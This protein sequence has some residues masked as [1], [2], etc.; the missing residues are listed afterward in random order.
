[1]V[2]G[3]YVDRGPD[4]RLVLDHLIRLGAARH[5][6]AAARQPRTHDAPRPRGWLQFG[7]LDKCRRQRDPRLVS[8]AKS[9]GHS[10]TALE[11][12]DTC[13][14]FYQ[15][16]RISLSTPTPTQIAASRPRGDMLYWQPFGYP[17]PHRS[18]RRMICGSH[19]ATGRAPPRPR[20]CGVPRYLR[21]RR[22]V[23][24]VPGGRPQAFTGK[25]TSCHRFA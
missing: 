2:L 8:S 3:D 1:V 25:R 4:S 7:G 20:T 13:R 11:V 18:G 17:S 15:T 6:C 14:P 23:V 9:R 12:S 16:D 24:D 10:R 5:A 19:G 21:L 22:R